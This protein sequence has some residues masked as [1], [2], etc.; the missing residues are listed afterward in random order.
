MKRNYFSHPLGC[1]SVFC[2]FSIV[3]LMMIK[4]HRPMYKV[5]LFMRLRQK[6]RAENEIMLWN[7]L[8]SCC[9][10]FIYQLFT[11]TQCSFIPNVG[12]ESLCVRCKARNSA[13]HVRRVAFLS[14]WSTATEPKECINRKQWANLVN[15]F[16]IFV[17]CIL[18]VSKKW[19]QHR[20]WRWKAA[21][22][23]NCTHFH[24]L[25]LA[26]PFPTVVQ[27]CIPNCSHTHK[28]FHLSL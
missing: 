17:V 4:L 13:K 5:L 2:F 28:H 25:P 20:E 27:T 3:K 23:E 24:L 6:K 8:R 14:L 11:H 12:L 18:I 7:A 26:F 22:K 10:T 19:A 9:C 15:I 1:E 16:P 21:D